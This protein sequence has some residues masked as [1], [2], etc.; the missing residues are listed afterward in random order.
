MQIFTENSDIRL[1]QIDIVVHVAHVPL[2]FVPPLRELLD[3]VIQKCDPFFVVDN[4]LS[5]RIGRIKFF[6]LSQP[7][8]K[9][10]NRFYLQFIARLPD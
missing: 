4:R 1:L 2:G 6:R 9:M 10:L 8:Q 3:H 7:N 5:L